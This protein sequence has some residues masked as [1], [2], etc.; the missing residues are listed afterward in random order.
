LKFAGHIVK[1]AERIGKEAALEIQTPFSEIDILNENKDFIF[2][3][4]PTV[5]HITIL[6]FDDPTEIENSK[7]SREQALPGKPAAFFY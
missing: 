5:K 4:M 6:K 2:D 7:N 3:N 1:E